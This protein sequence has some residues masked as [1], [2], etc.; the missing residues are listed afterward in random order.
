MKK[1]LLI[2]ASHWHLKPAEKYPSDKIAEAEKLIT[3]L[4]NNAG[5]VR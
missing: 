1:Q 3:D 2:T 4:E 5:I